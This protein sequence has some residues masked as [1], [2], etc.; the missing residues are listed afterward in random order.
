MMDLKSR[1]PQKTNR[2]LIPS[3]RT[4]F[5][6]PRSIGGSI[7]K[8]QPFFKAKKEKTLIYPLLIDLEDLIVEYVMQLWIIYRLV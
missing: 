6:L 5:Q 7:G 3:L 1:N 2:W 8:V 4:K